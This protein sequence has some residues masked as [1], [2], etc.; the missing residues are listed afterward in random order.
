MANFPVSAQCDS[1][2]IDKGKVG[3]AHE[4]ACWCLMVNQ[5]FLVVPLQQMQVKTRLRR[6]FGS[7]PPAGGRLSAGNGCCL[8]SGEEA[9]TLLLPNPGGEESANHRLNG[10]LLRRAILR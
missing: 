8:D 3:G 1:G 2:L 7:A 9:G 4:V 5:V 6:E 10:F